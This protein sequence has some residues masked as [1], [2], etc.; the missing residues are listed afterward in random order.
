MALNPETAVIARALI[1]LLKTL[2]EL[3]DALLEAAPSGNKKFLD[4][5]AAAHQARTECFEQVQK[6]MNLMEKTP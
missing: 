2:V 5:I 6:L 4:H 3:D 1:A